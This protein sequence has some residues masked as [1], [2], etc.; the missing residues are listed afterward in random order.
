M[1]CPLSD[2][3]VGPTGVDAGGLVGQEGLREVKVDMV[4]S[5]G[6]RV[7][8]DD[9]EDSGTRQVELGWAHHHAAVKDQD[10]RLGH[11]G[12]M[13]SWRVQHQEHGSRVCQPLWLVS[14]HLGWWQ[15]GPWK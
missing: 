7:L 4:D 1:D 11:R 12:D 3:R 2:I 9:L 8:T 14:I 13:M 15:A 6:V 10:L 5:P